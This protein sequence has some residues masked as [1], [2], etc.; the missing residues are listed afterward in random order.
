MKL[1]V[2]SEERGP[3]LISEAINPA[4]NL[5]DKSFHDWYHQIYIKEVAQTKGWRR[6]TRFQNTMARNGTG[7]GSGRW[8]AL[9]EFE[10]GAFESSGKGIAS[11]LGQSKETKQV[12][13]TAKGID[14][15][16]FKLA[17]QYGNTTV[18]WGDIGGEKII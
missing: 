7:G 5:T 8:L 1:T 6:T 16:P 13:D 2:A 18:P 3:L 9:H 17:R 10:D 11:L 12:Q 15:A 14:I 4:E